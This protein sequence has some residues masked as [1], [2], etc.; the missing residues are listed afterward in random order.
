MVALKPLT[1][2]RTR[3]MPPAATARLTTVP[4]TAAL[5]AEATCSIQ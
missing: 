3:A 2:T 5:L 1:V 4:A